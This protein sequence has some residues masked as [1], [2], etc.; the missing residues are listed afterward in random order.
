M[1]L[2]RTALQLAGAALVALGAIQPAAAHPPAVSDRALEVIQSRGAD[3]VDLILQYRGKPSEADADQARGKGASV[4]KELGLINGHAISVP[5][6]AALKLL[7]NPNVKAV[8]VDEP[9][10]AAYYTVGSSSVGSSTTSVPTAVLH[11]YPGLTTLPWDGTGIRVAVIDSG[12]RSHPDGKPIA[13]QSFVAGEKEDD[14]FGHGNHVA[15]RP[16]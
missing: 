1:K 5:A 14:N 13:K 9:L 8:S 6:Q 3:K 10:T 4:R 7:D 16:T 15:R 12:M 11:A 2:F